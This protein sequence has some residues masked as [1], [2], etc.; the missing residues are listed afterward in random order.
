MVGSFETRGQCCDCLGV[1]I[2]S[3]CA[4]DPLTVCLGQFYLFI[5]SSYALGCACAIFPASYYF[6]YANVIN[7]DKNIN[8]FF[9]K[10]RFP[11]SQMPLCL[12]F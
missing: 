2:I 12:A 6:T 9:L 10:F 3:Y 1:C 5:V 8:G 4:V 7:D 11:A